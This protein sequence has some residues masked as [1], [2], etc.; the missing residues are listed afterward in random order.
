MKKTLLIMLAPPEGESATLFELTF[1]NG[2]ITATD[3]D[4]LYAR[5]KTWQLSKD[6]AE[7]IDKQMNADLYN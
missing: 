5:L 2:K 1:N 3:G 6:E 7:E 4:I